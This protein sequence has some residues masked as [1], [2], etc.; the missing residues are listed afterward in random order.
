MS[1]RFDVIER[2]RELRSRRMV[3]ISKSRVNK[4]D[5]DLHTL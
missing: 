4:K 2:R 5:N 1:S 3:P